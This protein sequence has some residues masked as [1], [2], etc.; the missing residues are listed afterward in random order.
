MTQVHLSL[1]MSCLHRLSYGLEYSEIKNSKR[2]RFRI[3][4]SNAEQ[5]GTTLSGVH[6]V[7]TAG[8]LPKHLRTAGRSEPA[9][10]SPNAC[11]CVRCS[12]LVFRGFEQ[13]GQQGIARITEDRVCT[14]QAKHPGR[15]QTAHEMY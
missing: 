14:V 4:D 11:Q 12:F 3:L 5:H 2:I 1:S 15:L 9:K 7:R 13:S 10:P 6:E 8:H